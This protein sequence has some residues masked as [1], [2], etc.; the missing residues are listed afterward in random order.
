MGTDVE[1]TLTNTG[2]KGQKQLTVT[3]ILQAEKEGVLKELKDYCKSLKCEEQKLDVEVD[4][5][6]IDKLVGIVCKDKKSDLANVM[7]TNNSTSIMLIY[8][9]RLDNKDLLEEIVSEIQSH[10]QNQTVIDIE[11]NYSSVKR[12][13]TSLNTVLKKIPFTIQAS[14]EEKTQKLIVFSDVSE[15]MYEKIDAALDKLDGK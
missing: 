13:E 8:Y 10:L 14:E 7:L 9:K 12:L 3:G 15:D 6:T 1:I 5:E 2:K 11:I 4:D